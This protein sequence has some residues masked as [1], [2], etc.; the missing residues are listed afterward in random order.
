MLLED[1]R[2][3]RGISEKVGERQGAANDDHQRPVRPVCPTR[4]C[5]HSNS[6]CPEAPPEQL[7]TAPPGQACRP[8]PRG[9]GA[10]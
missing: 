4:G 3:R 1:A 7:Q 2:V 10:R 9:V 6:L 5:Q 8:S